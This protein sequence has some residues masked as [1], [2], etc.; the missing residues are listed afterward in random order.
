MNR[1][2]FLIFIIGCNAAFGQTITGIL[3]NSESRQPI[4]F[5]NIGIVGKNVGTVTDVN[6]RFNFHVDPKYDNDT[7]LFSIIGY[8]T[9]LIKIADLRKQNENIVLL[10]EK[11][12]ELT[13]LIIKPKIFKQRT[14]GVTTKFK[15]FTAGFE[16]NKLGYELGALMR[17]KKTAFIRNVNI[18]IA[19]CSYDT[20]FYRL[21]I[22]KVK[23]EMDFENILREPIYIEM[24]K[25]EVKDQIQV[26]LQS[27]NI[28]VDGDF[29]ITLEHVKDLG[30]G[31]L[32]FCAGLI[33]RTYYR[34]TSQGKWETAPVG[35]SISVIADVEE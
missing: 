4:E 25:E 20:I 10:D 35:I 17:I 28:V 23:G 5:A 29:L 27:K 12:Y 18:N 32:Y 14:L 22:Y 31:N 16:D 2:L 11:T 34:K 1:F 33:N 9:R 21:N 30:K 24:T 15:G 3:F 7:T 6:G 13:E 8:K 19:H 26:D